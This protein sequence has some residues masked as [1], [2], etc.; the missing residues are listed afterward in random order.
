MSLTLVVTL[1]E[2]EAD[3]FTTRLKRQLPAHS[4]LCWQCPAL[5][6]TGE[7]LGSQTNLGSAPESSASLIE[8]VTQLSDSQFLPL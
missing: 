2:C 7:N 4:V 6:L 3:D 8:Q 5:Q 1:G